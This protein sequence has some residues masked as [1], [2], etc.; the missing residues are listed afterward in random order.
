[1][2]GPTA[3]VLGKEQDFERK[4]LIRGGRSSVQIGKTPHSE[5]KDYLWY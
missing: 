5:E 1:M 2:A 3:Q 4:Q